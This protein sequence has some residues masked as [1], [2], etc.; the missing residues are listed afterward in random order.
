MASWEMLA[1]EELAF[2]RQWRTEGT[3]ARRYERFGLCK[4]ADEALG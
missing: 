4:R 3:R 1:L 2:L